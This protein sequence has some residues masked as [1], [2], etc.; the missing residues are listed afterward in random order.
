MRSARGA[1]FSIYGSLNF[2]DML[3][4]NLNVGGCLGFLNDTIESNNRTYICMSASSDS[5]NIHKYTHMLS[6]LYFPVI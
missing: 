4:G 5:L 3:D 6:R 1:N 2:L